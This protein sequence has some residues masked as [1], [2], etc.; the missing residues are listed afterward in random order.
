MATT[1]IDRRTALKLVAAAT[2]AALAP[3]RLSAEEAPFMT[4]RKI[5]GSGEL[6]TPAAA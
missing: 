5:P 4:T 2:A 3:S 6:W 1:R